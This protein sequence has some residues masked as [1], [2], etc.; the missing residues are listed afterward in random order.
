MIL[1]EGQV[2][3]KVAVKGAG[4]HARDLEY[5]ALPETKKNKQRGGRNEIACSLERYIN[6]PSNRSTG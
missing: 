6:N 2:V 3:E 1:R 4:I 5:T